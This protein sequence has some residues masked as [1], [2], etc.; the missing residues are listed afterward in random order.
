MKLPASGSIL[1]AAAIALAGFGPAPV[2]PST[3]DKVETPTQEELLRAGPLGDRAMGNANAPVVLIEY[4][5]L[6]CPHCR[7]FHAN[8]FPKVKSQYIDTGK[9]R[10]IV[11]EFPIGR[12]AG[13][14]AIINRCAPPDQYFALLDAFLSRQDEWVSQEVRLD[15][16]YGVAKSI[17]MSREAF[18]K[19]LS[20]QAI[21]EGLTEVKQRGRQFGVVGTPTFFVNGRKA[22]GAIT[23]EEIKAL[24]EPQA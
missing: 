20:N 7:N 16:I 10:Y 18:D 21:I 3:P 24:I 6:T 12:S 2:T 14:A 15:A 23:F 19:C 17:G 13:N 4:A 1:I 11:R 22:Q 9:V 5:S 8:V